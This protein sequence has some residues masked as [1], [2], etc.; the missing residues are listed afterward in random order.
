[1]SMRPGSR[2]AVGMCGQVKV[3][4]TIGGFRVENICFCL[5]FTKQTERSTEV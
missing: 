5:I 4:S 2:E 3:E 1:M